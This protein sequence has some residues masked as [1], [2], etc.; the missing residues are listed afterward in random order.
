MLPQHFESSSSI[1]R[2]IK[3]SLTSVNVLGNFFLSKKF[4]DILL[5]H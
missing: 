2:I 4:L 3:I 1:L 5:K